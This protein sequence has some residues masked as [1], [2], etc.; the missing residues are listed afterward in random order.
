MNH[1]PGAAFAVVATGLGVGNAVQVINLG[2]EDG[3]P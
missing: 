3:L 2:R 1:E